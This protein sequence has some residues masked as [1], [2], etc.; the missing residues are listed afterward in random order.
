MKHLRSILAA[1]LALALSTGAALAQSGQGSS[2][3]TGAKGGT[4]NG[5]MQFT[6]PA[7]SLKT[8]TLPNASD[9]IATLGAIQ[10]FTAAK[11]FASAK[12][13]LAGSTSGAGTLN[14]PAI[15][16]TYV[17]TLP[18]AT[19]TL[20][21]KA[22]T[23]TLTNKTF[24]TAGTGNSFSINGLAATSN[25]G[26]GAV[27]RATSPTLVTPALGTPASGVLTNAT[28]LPISTGVSGL[29]TGVATA[30]ATPSS[31]NIAAAVTDETGSGALVF[32]TSPALTTPNLGTPSAATL[33][34]ATG[35]PVA[36]GISGLGTGVATFLATPSSSNL[37]TA[38]T[39]ETGTGALVFAT[40]P[41]L[42]SPAL[43]TPASGTLT[44]ATGLPISTG[45][46]GLGTGVATALATPSSAN[47]AAAVT[48]ETGSG[49]L[50]FATSPALTTPNLGTPS[51][52]TLTNATGLPVST[53][54]SGLGTGVATALAT[55]SSANIA[56]AVTD[57]TGSGA[58]VFGTSPT[59]AT[60]AITG[61]A[62]IQGAP[63]FTGISSPSQITAT[64]N[65]YNP[66][67][68][69]CSTAETLRLTS[70]ASRDVTGLAGGVT[71]CQL[72]IMNV[73]SNPIVLKDQAAGSTAG[74]RMALGGDATV[75]SQASYALRY[76]GTSSRW[77][78]LVSPGAG[79]G[80]GGGVT[81]V[82]C[83]EGAL[84]STITTTGTVKTTFARHFMMGGM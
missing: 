53:G 45:V 18:A 73:G 56:A 34:N 78:P 26:T 30:L 25:T 79:G 35:L 28:G 80:G 6:G 49:A 44:N 47:V 77:R 60:P 24:D 75:A 69:I 57:E 20:V 5:F 12:L 14:A 17:W 36:T 22:T 33:T 10:T 62:D 1:A 13:L 11:T 84:C 82:A 3:L 2:P 58:L 54:I 81:S 40:S 67:S 50:V 46:S 42:V 19:D 4:N 83:A 59:I 37:A 70:D 64:Q 16:S 32:A 8:Y 31:S 65:D 72:V 71:G 51:A 38:V 43:G 41:T 68:V 66:S 63:K 29:G 52:A 9:T 48:D 76:D 7:S 21:G 23:D 27:V 61:L 39:G 55:P 74:N 15:A